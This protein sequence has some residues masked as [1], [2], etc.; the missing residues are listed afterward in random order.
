MVWWVYSCHL[1]CNRWVDQLMTLGVRWPSHGGHGPYRVGNPGL[2]S[3]LS[4]GFMSLVT[5]AVQMRFSSTG[6]GP[7]AQRQ[8]GTASLEKQCL[9][10]IRDPRTG[11]RC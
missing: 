5:C 4:H 3:E 1:V 7:G 6:W 9:G 11:P 2:T 10:E 8:P